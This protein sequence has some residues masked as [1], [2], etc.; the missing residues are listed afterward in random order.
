MP[1]CTRINARPA[2]AIAGLSHTPRIPG[3][4]FLTR[5]TTMGPTTLDF[6][7]FDPGQKN[8]SRP[9]V[10]ARNYAYADEAASPGGAWWGV[11]GPSWGVDC[12]C[13]LRR[14]TEHRRRHVRHLRMGIGRVPFRP[15][16]RRRHFLKNLSEQLLNKVKSMRFARACPLT[17]PQF[18]PPSETPVSLQ[19]FHI[20]RARLGTTYGVG[21]DDH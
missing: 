13:R 10:V 16:E 19:K 12:T 2:S 15:T 17:R 5:H 7:P 1:G 9:P 6:R 18:S 14:S 20:R 4:G 8:P 3:G 21:A 11:P